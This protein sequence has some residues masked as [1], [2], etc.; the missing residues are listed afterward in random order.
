MTALINTLSLTAYNIQNFQATYL[1]DGDFHEKSFNDLEVRVPFSENLGSEVTDHYCYYEWRVYPSSQFRDK[2][3][4]NVPVFM[5]LLSASVFFVISVAFFVYD[6]FVHKRNTKIIDAAARS[7]AIILSLFPA[8][9]RDQLLAQS[10]W[11]QTMKDN[12]K[13]SHFSN[14]SNG[15]FGVEETTADASL[16]DSPPIADLFPGKGSCVRY[17]D[18]FYLFSRAYLF[19]WIFQNVLL[20]LQTVSIELIARGL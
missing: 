10:K 5:T 14:D 12:V 6:L 1:G 9:V 8:K 2:L 17:L 7:N 13:R 20:C 3:Q 16:A 18:T 19:V 4:E 15:L 11:D